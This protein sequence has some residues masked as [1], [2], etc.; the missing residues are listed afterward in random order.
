MW[1]F[2]VPMSCDELF[3]KRGLS[4]DDEE[5]FA[6]ID[7]DGYMVGKFPIRVR[8]FKQFGE[9]MQEHRTKVIRFS[10]DN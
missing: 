8:C 4:D 7:P 3:D 10:F 6:D 5:I 2:E 9:C 1:R